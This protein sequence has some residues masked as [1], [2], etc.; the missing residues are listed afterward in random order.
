MS[1]LTSSVPGFDPGR[2]LI[3]R[4]PSDDLGIRGRL[5][6]VEQREDRVEV[7]VGAVLGHDRGDD[8]L[9]GALGEERLG[10]ALD[11]PARRPFGHADGDRSLADDLDVA[12]LQ[13]RLAEVLDPEPL[14]LAELRI[15]ELE[16]LVLEARMGA[17]DRRHVVGLAPT[18]GPIHR[19]D[20]DAAVDPARRV[21]REQA[22]R[23]R[24]QDEQ[25]VSSM[26]AAMS[27]VFL[28]RPRSSP[29]SATV[30]PPIR[31]RASASGGRADRHA[32]TSSTRLGPTT[33]SDAT[34][35]MT[36]RRASSLAV[37]ASLSRSWT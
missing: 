26:A 30:R 37:S 8:P 22:V 35:S 20:R 24:R 27:D 2:R 29:D 1:G 4:M 21:A 12:A 16:G 15:P 23:Q 5:V 11:H 18:C 9:G 31:W 32:W 3:A 17:V 6:A 36:R 10:D 33:A 28:S 25:G 13:R 19:V 14:V 7:H 34:S